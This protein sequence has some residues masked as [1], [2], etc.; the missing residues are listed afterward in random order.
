M[1]EGEDPGRPLPA[2]CGIEADELSE[3]AVASLTRAIAHHEAHLAIADDGGKFMA[4]T[5]VGLCYGMLGDHLAAA[6]HHQEALRIAIQLQSF[7]GQSI[8]V[9]NL[10]RAEKPRAVRSL[11]RVPPSRFWAFLGLWCLLGARHG[12]PACAPRPTCMRAMPR[13]HLT[14]SSCACA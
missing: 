13:S 9:G 14:A 11:V 8:S 5:N 1:R 3:E 7:S 10:P 12:S 2:N 6:R 4:R